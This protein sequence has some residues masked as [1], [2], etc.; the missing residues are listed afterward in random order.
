MDQACTILLRIKWPYQAINTL[1][2]FKDCISLRFVLP[3]TNRLKERDAL[4]CALRVDYFLDFCL[5]LKHSMKMHFYN[6]AYIPT[7]ERHASTCLRLHTFRYTFS[8]DFIIRDA[9]L[10][11]TEENSWAKQASTQI[12]LEKI[13]CCGCGLSYH[14]RQ[15]SKAPATPKGH[16]RNPKNSQFVSSNDFF[17]Q[18]K[19]KRGDHHRTY[20]LSRWSL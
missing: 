8:S 17:H 20:L 13:K 6:Q 15:Q 18:A 1:W 9:N 14:S 10:H 4:L 7:C 3:F 19:S 11:L 5:C 16:C 12:N 2:L